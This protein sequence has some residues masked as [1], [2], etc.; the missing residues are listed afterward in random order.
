MVP[1]VTSRTERTQNRE[2]LQ[3]LTFRVV[4][5][6]PPTSHFGSPGGPGTSPL[7]ARSSDERRREQV[8]GKGESENTKTRIYS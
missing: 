3:K 6:F 1:T 4:P 5:R 2:I 8:G 7:Q